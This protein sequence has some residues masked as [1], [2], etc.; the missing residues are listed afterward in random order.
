MQEMPDTRKIF[1]SALAR[2]LG[3]A[4]TGTATDVT[5]WLLLEYNGPWHEKATNDNDLPPAVQAHLDAALATIPS[6]RLLFIKQQRAEEGGVSFFVARTDERAPQLARFELAN[7]EA[8]I[9]LDLEAI[10]GGE[11]GFAERIVDEPLFLVC[12]N[13]KRDKCCAKFGLPMFQAVAAAAPEITW[14]STHMGGHRYAPNMMFLPH[15]VNYGL[16]SPEEGAAAV[17]AHQRGEIYSLAHYRG[18]TY[19]PA[20]INAADTFLRQETGL[21]RL[22]DLVL[23]EEEEVADNRWQIV[24]ELTATGERQALML[25]SELTAEPR[26]TSCSTPALAPVERFR[27]LR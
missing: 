16:L 23:R 19:Y 22:D 13:G 4:V 7:Y 21:M 26:L 6:S 20:H 25:E 2:E 5:V 11:G 17:A 24:F 9:D 8:L 10:A 15:S 1:C 18:R 3:D 14:Q 12:T 27:L